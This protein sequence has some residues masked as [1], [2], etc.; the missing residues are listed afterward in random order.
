MRYFMTMFTPRIGKE[1]VGLRNQP[2][3]D[4]HKV[5]HSKL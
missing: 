3:E 5:F 1:K 2:S 4:R